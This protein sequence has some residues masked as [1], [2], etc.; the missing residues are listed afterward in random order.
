MTKPTKPK[1][2]PRRLV[3]IL[4]TTWLLLLL[5]AGLFVSNIYIQVNKHDGLFASSISINDTPIGGLTRTEATKMLTET[6]IQP[7]LKQTV[8]LIDPNSTTPLTLT[9]E[10]LG[11]T[12]NLD[13]LLDKADASSSEGTFFERY[14][15]IKKGLS[16]PLHLTLTPTIDEAK[17][18]ALLAQHTDA[19]YQAPIDATMKRINKSFTFT[20]EASG[21]KLDT[22]ALKLQMME[23]LKTNASFEVTVPLLEVAPTYTVSYLKEL[24]TP[25][26]S[27]STR[28][29]NA[30]T[31]R[32]ENIRLASLKINTLLM[33]NEKFKFSEQLEPIDV[34]SGYQYAK[35]IANGSFE[36]GLGGGICQVS[37][38][39]YNAI[40]QTDL[41]IYMRRNHSLPVS[42]T[43]LGLDATY[44][45]NSVD[46][47]FI[48]NS[49][50]PL[51]VESYTENNQVFVTLY[52]HQSFKPDY[53]TKF[54]SIIE[55]E[56]QPG[57]PRYEDDPTLPVGKE[58]QK[59]YPKPGY[60]V[61]VYKYYYKN[62]ELIKKEKLNTSKYKPQVG[63]IRRGTMAPT[64][65][66]SPTS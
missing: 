26:A 23:G 59:A 49:G 22:E 4:L 8:T 30:D 20:S 1:K 42:Y 48:N 28:Y 17:I 57:A 53:T 29:N 16:T 46:F 3:P 15:L 21:H 7:F 66:T 18:E 34:A 31:L 38:T 54:E 60:K 61:T 35:V 40:I 52:G 62:G 51:Y 47:Q 58:V 25:L 37:S 56:I 63:I 39:L 55:E 19:F 6:F 32:N 50:H 14:Q 44:A 13:T 9:Y 5:G 11:V 33:P 43:P 36:E 64:S 41:D 24:Q 65:P 2:A 45:T 10:E 27:F 12:Y